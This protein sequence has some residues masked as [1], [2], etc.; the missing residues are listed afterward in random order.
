V[1]KDVGL[2]Q[3]PRGRETISIDIK[4]GAAEFPVVE[5]PLGF[6][7]IPTV[8]NASLLEPR[9]ASDDD[10][11]DHSPG[12]V[13]RRQR[14]Q[15]GSSLREQAWHI[16]RSFGIPGG[17]SRGFPREFSR[18][19]IKAPFHYVELLRIVRAIVIVPVT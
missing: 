13:V 19:A 1:T 7:Q 18:A 17:G 14:G 15:P 2:S 8:P 11:M 5:Q 10:S 4:V 12:A 16:K 6:G 9:N 3:I